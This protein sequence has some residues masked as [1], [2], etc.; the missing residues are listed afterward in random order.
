MLSDNHAYIAGID[1]PEIRNLNEGDQVVPAD[2]TK[3]ILSRGQSSVRS[4]I[5]RF[6]AGTVTMED[7]SEQ[8]LS[9]SLTEKAGGAPSN[10]Q[11]STSTGGSSAKSAKTAEELKEEFEKLY[12]E[13]QHLLAMDQESQEDYL[14]WLDK[15]YQEYYEKGALELDD[16]N[17][18]QKEVYQSN[19]DL[20]KDYLGDNEHKIDILG[21]EDGNEDKIVSIYEE[22]MAAIDEE[23]AA[24]KARGLDSNDDYVQELESQ[25]WSYKN[26]IVDIEEEAAEKAQEAIEEERD[27]FSDYL[28]DIEHQIERLGREDGNNA[29]IINLYNT[30]IASIEKQ[31][32]EA[33]ASGLDDND[34]Y[35][36]ELE[37]Q[38]WSYQDEISNMTDSVTDNAMD[39][40][41]DL[42]QYRIK[43][44]K[45]DLENEIDNLNDKKDALKDFYDEQK[46]MLQDVYD[47]KKY[48]E[49]QSEKRK[50]VSD[51]EAELSMLAFDNSAWAQKRKLELQEEL[52]EAQKELSDFEEDKALEDA[53]DL[54]D[55]L[56]ENQAKQIDS[57]IESLEAALNN[58][59]AL[60]NQA[61]SDIQNNTKALYDE[62]VEY[63]ARY[64]D[65]N[66]ETVKTMWD[67]A[68]ASLDNFLATFGT[69][70]KDIVPVSSGGYAS[71][72]NSATPGLKKVDEESAE[73]LFTSGDGT[74]YRVFSGG[75]KVLNAD[76]TN[77]LYNFATNGGQFLSNI[78][79]D[80]LKAFNIGNVS[81]P[82]QQIQLTTGNIII[83]GNADQRTVS[84]IRRAQREGIDHV[85]K[86]FARLNK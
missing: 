11:G 80:V 49:E 46:E 66:A 27:A 23:L 58:P 39:A 82:S 33:R 64:G 1:G 84:E 20:F 69:A 34:E 22:M 76:A 37:S 67:D 85:L 25:W 16:F 10:T 73:W 24:A 21:Y 51:I 6:Y 26:A 12:K 59:E 61:L 63:N 68:K 36:Q 5:P 56:Y 18:Y 71:G 3:K 8:K 4:I 83:E 32:A 41:D 86:E 40:I 7:L 35:I 31:I 42:I 65:G 47:E 9:S 52:A 62:M 13:H 60:Y 75:E 19:K 54:L 2:E 53:Q 43:M 15:A 38:L 77:F 72:T 81:S 28:N 14:A 78:F 70:Y 50:A 79:S 45:Q 48:L 30:M 55:T 74:R 44:L 17:K 29:E 57:E